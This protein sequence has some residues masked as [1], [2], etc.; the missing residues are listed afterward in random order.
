MNNQN[1]KLVKDLKNLLDNYL[2]KSNSQDL[3]KVLEEDISI[4]T[5]S[6][7]EIVELDNS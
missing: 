5:L 3:I 1:Q 6:V 2:T 7:N 4:Q